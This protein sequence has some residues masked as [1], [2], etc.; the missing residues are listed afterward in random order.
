VHIWLARILALGWAGFWIWFGLAWG[1][2][3]R[4][5]WYQVVLQGSRP[6]LLFLAIVLIAWFWPKWGGVLLILTGFALAGLYPIYWASLP[7]NTK[8]FGEA[9]IA[10]PP[11]VSGLIQVIQPTR[12][13]RRTAISEQ[14]NVRPP[15]TAM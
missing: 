7:T 14:T 5:P 10:L 9:T 4:L 15:R 2:H 8:L 1:I 11:L 13:S 6:G 3:E 12:A